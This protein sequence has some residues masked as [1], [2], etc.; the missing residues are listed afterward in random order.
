MLW[1]NI[2]NNV[3]LF[4]KEIFILW[5]VFLAD[6][7]DNLW[8]MTEF[9]KMDNNSV[10]DSFSPCSTIQQ[11]WGWNKSYIKEWL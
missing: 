5:L 9:L 11:S 2:K 3:D 1:E 4:G 10:L 7:E 8:Y 6:R